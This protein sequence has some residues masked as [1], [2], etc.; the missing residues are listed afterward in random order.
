MFIVMKKL[1]SA[2]D[3]RIVIACIRAC[4]WADVEGR[5][6]CMMRVTPLEPSANPSSRSFTSRW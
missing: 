5:P 4:V 6:F 2:Q 3:P 1:P